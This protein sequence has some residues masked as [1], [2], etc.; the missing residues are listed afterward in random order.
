MRRSNA[1]LLLFITF[2]VV[3]V[4]SASSSLS[5]SEDDFEQC[6]N[7]IKNWAASSLHTQQ[8]VK[9]DKHVLKDLLFF[10]H[11]PRTGGRTYFHCFLKKLY[12]SS[13]EC[14]RSYDKLRFNP[15]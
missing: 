12:S 4:L 8:V 15:R 5:E 3:T 10:L 2:L 6:E 9:E 13:F 14:P 11:I 7:S 1:P